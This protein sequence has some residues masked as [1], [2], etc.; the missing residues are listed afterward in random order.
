MRAER[1]L[2]TCLLIAVAPTPTAAQISCTSAADIA[3]VKAELKSCEG[4]VVTCK[5]RMTT[6][7]RMV[8]D[9]QA[10]KVPLQAC[11]ST[12]KGI[13]EDAQRAN[14]PPSNPT[15]PSTLAPRPRR[16]GGGGGG[17]IGDIN[18]F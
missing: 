4:T 5:A 14:L 16:G 10:G 2:L 1:V 15:V 7:D 6:V 12:L 11:S 13:Y 8:A 3:A 9:F 17:G 18:L